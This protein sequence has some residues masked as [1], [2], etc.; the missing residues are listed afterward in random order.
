MKTKKII[1]SALFISI[2]LILPTIFHTVSLSGSIFLPMHLPVMVGGF[3]LGPLYGAIIGFITPILSSILTGMPP[4]MPITPLM[5]LEL[6][7]YGFMS[8]L[9]FKKTKKIYISLLS[10]I[11]FGRLCSMIGAFILSITFAPQISPVPYVVSGIINGVPGI[12]IQL[13]I[14]PL[15]IKFIITNKETSQILEIN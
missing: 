3:I 4:L 6:L 10:S 11:L 5:S 9:L 8:G 7:G 1:L 12:I 13:I 14:V 2:G 15:L